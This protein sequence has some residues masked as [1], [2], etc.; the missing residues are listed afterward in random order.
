MF[1]TATKQPRPGAKRSF[2]EL[3]DVDICINSNKKKVIFITATTPKDRINFENN[4]SLIMNKQEAIKLMQNL[5]EKINEL[6]G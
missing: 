2:L 5:M 4:I 3:Y 1:A 6:E